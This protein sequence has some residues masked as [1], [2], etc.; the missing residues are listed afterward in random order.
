MYKVSSLLFTTF[1]RN[2]FR[3]YKYVVSLEI[4]TEAGA[5]IYLNYSF[6]LYVINENRHS[7][8]GFSKITRLNS[9]KLR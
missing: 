6:K 7:S 1:V 8:T 4:R 2:I 9:M 3:S 5:D